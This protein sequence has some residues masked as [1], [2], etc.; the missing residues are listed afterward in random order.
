MPI[1]LDRRLAGRVGLGGVSVFV[2][3]VL[4][5]HVLQPKLSPLTEAVSF[6]AHGRGGRLLTIGL[7]AMA[8]GSLSLAWGLARNSHGRIAKVG[9]VL[10]AVWGL[11]ALLGGIF[12]ADPPGNWDAPPSL[13]GMIH[14]NS[15]LVAFLSL[16]AA[17]VM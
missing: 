4:A 1:N 14:G 2:I 16:P 11:G 7:I 13:S 6:Y 10:L 17:A 15:A 3:A 12:P 9:V 8:I 5:L